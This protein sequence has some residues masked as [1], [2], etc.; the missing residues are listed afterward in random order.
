VAGVA[1]GQFLDD[2]ALGAASERSSGVSMADARRSADADG[3]TPGVV[4]N[5]R[6]T[7][8][9]RCRRRRL[10][11]DGSA[12]CADQPGPS[13]R[14]AARWARAASPEL[15]SAPRSCR[16]R[17]RARNS[18]RNSSCSA[19]FLARPLAR[20]PGARWPSR[21]WLSSVAKGAL[22]YAHGRRAAPPLYG[23]EK[24][25]GAARRRCSNY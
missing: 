8:G 20:E 16:W 11:A 25:D 6:R 9:G 13:G 3:A 22:T 14:S 23:V 21:K 4:R 12:G 24:T 19:A 2:D 17:R 10:S 15:G 7:S 1:L 5:S 18:A